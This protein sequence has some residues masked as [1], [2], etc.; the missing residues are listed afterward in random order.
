MLILTRNTDESIVIEDDIRITIIDV[1]GGQV[2]LG[3]DA[4]RDVA[5]HRQEIY[6]RIKAGVPMVPKATGR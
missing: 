2:R 6:E 3:I 1:K 4:P 5:V